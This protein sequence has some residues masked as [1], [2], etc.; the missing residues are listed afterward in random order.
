MDSLI[1]VGGLI[2]I[3]KKSFVGS[4]QA[5]KVPI[6]FSR[7]GCIS[8]SWVFK[9]ARSSPSF[10]ANDPTC[11]SL[12]P[13][14]K[15]L[16]SCVSY[17]GNDALLTMPSESACVYEYVKSGTMNPFAL[18]CTNDRVF[19]ESDGHN[20]PLKTSVEHVPCSKISF[21]NFPTDSHPSNVAPHRTRQAYYIRIAS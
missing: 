5:F 7:S 6:H 16:T 8:R 11:S 14:L 15:Y 18:Y 20:V 3:V 4:R 19:R 17:V 21:A 10:N 1:F 2:I 13:T 12:L 9:R